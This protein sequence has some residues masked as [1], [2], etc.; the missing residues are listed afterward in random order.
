[1]YLIV[2]GMFHGTGIRDKYEGGYL[3]LTDLNL[4]DSLIDRIQSWLKAYEEEHYNNY[5]NRSV[6]EKLDEEG[7]SITKHLSNIFP[8]S[9]ISYY[10]NARMVMLQ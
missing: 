3:N 9:K 1:M 10:S 8:N 6:V 4:P 5:K 7:I 2:D